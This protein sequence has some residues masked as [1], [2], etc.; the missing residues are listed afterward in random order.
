MKVLE[1]F[2]RILK[3]GKSVKIVVP[4]CRS[5][6][7]FMDPTHVHFFTAFSFDYFD[8]SSPL[9]QRYGYS[10]AKF[11]IDSLKFNHSSGSKSSPLKR[12]LVWVANK[13]PRGYERIVG[14]ILPLDDITFVL[15]KL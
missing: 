2:Y 12:L 8:P 13:K 15:R 7:A 3:P 5:V 10:S 4:H 9:C 11:A 14:H 6:W 1:E